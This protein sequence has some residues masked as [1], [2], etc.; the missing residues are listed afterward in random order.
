MKRT[1]QKGYPHLLSGAKLTRLNNRI[2]QRYTHIVVKN[3]MH[4]DEKKLTWYPLQM[5]LLCSVP[6]T[7]DGMRL[8]KKLTQSLS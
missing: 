1:D 3:D 8:D 5:L 7:E 6:I 2:H 4:P